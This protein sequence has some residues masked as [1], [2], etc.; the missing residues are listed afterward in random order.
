MEEI[1]DDVIAH[2]LRDEIFEKYCSEVLLFHP[3]I[4]SPGG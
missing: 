1:G 2:L 4:Y 3:L